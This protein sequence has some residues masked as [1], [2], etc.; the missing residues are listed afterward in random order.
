MQM[1][2]LAW[3]EDYA[4]PTSRIAQRLPVVQAHIRSFLD[5][6]D[7]PK[8]RV[9]SFCSGT[10]SDLLPVLA[11]HPA[12]ERVRARLVEFNP[13]LAERARAAAS[14]LELDEV[15]VVT[16]DASTAD[17]FEGAVPADL[18][19]VCGVFGNIPDS[20]VERTVRVLPQFSAE[21][22]T[23]IWTRHREEPDL[24]PA[25]R[26]WFSQTGFAELAFDSSGIGSY[27]VGSNELVA[28]PQ[29]LE[30]GVRLFTFTRES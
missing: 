19:L 24:T 23:V 2:W 17:A 28:E 3:H 6:C 12:R 16:G 25:I 9:I 18:V 15:E 8:I 5:R 22:A 27:A 4:D 14:E 21:G 30:S 7:A 11:E 13:E 29:P 1:D 10:G 26:A 20:D